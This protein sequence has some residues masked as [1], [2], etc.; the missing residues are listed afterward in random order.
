MFEIEAS[1]LPQY[2]ALVR[3]T[4]VLERHCNATNIYIYIYIYNPY[5]MRK[6]V[7]QGV[8]KSYISMIF[9]T[10]NL[11][12]LKNYQIKSC[13]EIYNCFVH[14]FINTNSRENEG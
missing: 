2:M 7:K 10:K 5:V 6:L 3:P 4:F 1:K 9:E 12:N 8:F 14:V 13:S 11:S